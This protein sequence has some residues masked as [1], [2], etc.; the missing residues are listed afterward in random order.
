VNFQITGATTT[1]VVSLGQPRHEVRHA[2]GAYR[3]FRRTRESRES[4][5]FT[6]SGVIATYTNAETVAMLEFVAP[7]QVEVAGVQLLGRPIQALAELLGSQSVQIEF[8][9]LGARMPDLSIEL[10]APS[11]VVEGVQLGS[12]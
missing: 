1:S 11:G 3:S 2:L 7:A 8:D 4:D 5:Q 9:D 10:F 6:D 12:E